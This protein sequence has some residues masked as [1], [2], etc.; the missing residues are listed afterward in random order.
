[1]SAPYKNSFGA[2]LGTISARIV[3]LGIQVE[4]HPT[5]VLTFARL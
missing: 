5:S 3:R 2:C 1:M 4:H